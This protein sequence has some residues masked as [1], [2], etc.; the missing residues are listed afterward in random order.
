MDKKLHVPMLHMDSNTT[1][2]VHIWRTKSLL[3][4]FE[5]DILDQLAILERRVIFFLLSVESRVI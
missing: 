4:V 2:V 3:I 1:L 5:Q